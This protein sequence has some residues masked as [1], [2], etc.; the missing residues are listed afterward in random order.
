MQQAVAA[1]RGET[2]V[3]ATE[4]TARAGAL[5]VEEATERATAGRLTQATLAGLA[6]A[7]VRAQPAMASICR[8]ANAVLLAAHP[9]TAEAVARAVA[10]CAEQL[11]I[12]V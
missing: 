12:T 6:R 9:P 3:G 2:R 11:G 7:L 5:L 10:A 1:I 8:L 4:L